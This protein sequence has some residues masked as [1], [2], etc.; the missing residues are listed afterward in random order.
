M[1]PVNWYSVSL[2]QKAANVYIV[3]FV[4]PVTTYLY[5]ISASVIKISMCI[6]AHGGWCKLWFG[7]R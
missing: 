7:G 1:V 4:F 3:F 6:S 2:N 5:S